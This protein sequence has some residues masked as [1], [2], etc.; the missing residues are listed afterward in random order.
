MRTEKKN[1]S[2]YHPLAHKLPFFFI[3]TLRT[4]THRLCVET[5]VGGGQQYVQ[6]VERNFAYLANVP[7]GAG[8]LLQILV[9]L[10][11]NSSLR[12]TDKQTRVGGWQFDDHWQQ[13]KVQGTDRQGLLSIR[14]KQPLRDLTMIYSLSPL[15]PDPLTSPTYPLSLLPGPPST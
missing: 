1:W 6:Y 5:V 10:Q 11:Y 8:H 15:S 9:H 4:D 12:L 14:D 13:M 3:P 2:I 7:L